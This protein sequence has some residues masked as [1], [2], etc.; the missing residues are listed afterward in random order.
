MAEAQGEARK[1]VTMDMEGIYHCIFIGGLPMYHGAATQTVQ[2]QYDK[3][4]EGIAL[5]FALAERRGMEEAAKQCD[6]MS[7]EEGFKKN[8]GGEDGEVMRRSGGWMM[9]QCPGAIRQRAKGG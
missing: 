1:L 2:A 5:A 7:L 3:V 8:A 4:V 6:A 9:M